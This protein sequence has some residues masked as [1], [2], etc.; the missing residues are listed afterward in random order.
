MEALAV[1][2]SSG[3]I[4]DLIAELRA[5][6]HPALERGERERRAATSMC[7]SELVACVAERERCGWPTRI[8]GSSAC[9]GSR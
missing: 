6:L 5:E 7:A 1:R 9:S 2:V 3:E 8:S 4:E